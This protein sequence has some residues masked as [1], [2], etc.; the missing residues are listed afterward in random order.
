[1]LQLA[2]T[3]YLTEHNALTMDS[4]GIIM[5]NLA[6]RCKALTLPI[7]HNGK[8]SGLCFDAEGKRLLSCGVDRNVKVW[9][10]LDTEEAGQTV[11]I[12]LF[13]LQRDPLMPCEAAITYT[14]YRRKIRIQVCLLLFMTSF[15]LRILCL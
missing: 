10:V 14:C 6:Q 4:L 9:D 2:K 8:V 1:M 3:F 15:A 13:A 12:A 7:A 5:H 11:C